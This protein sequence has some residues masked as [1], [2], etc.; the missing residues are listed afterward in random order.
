MPECYTCGQQIVFDKSIISKT[1]K[2]IP[3]WT[4]KKNAHGHD[5]NGNPI[6]QPIPIIGAQ[7]STA[8]KQQ[9]RTSTFTTPT[10]I[11]KTSQGGSYLDLKRTRVML[12]ELT[13]DVRELKE[14]VNSRTILDTQRYEGKSDLMFNAWRPFFNTQGVIASELQKDKQQNLDTSLINHSKK[15]DENFAKQNTTKF[16]DESKQHDFNI[17]ERIPD[18]NDEMLGAA[19]IIDDNNND[20]EGVINDE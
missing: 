17:D 3:L 13:K 1:G 9:Y 15:A 19:A 8:T 2:P 18:N 5:Q 10:D 20:Q 6:R 11:P 4:D 12:E 16:V 14:I 7:P